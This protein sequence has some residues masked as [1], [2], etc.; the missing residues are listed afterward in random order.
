MGALVSTK[1][2]SATRDL[3]VKICKRVLCLIRPL[4]SVLSANTKSNPPIGLKTKSSPI[5]P[6]Q[7]K[8]RVTMS[9]MVAHHCKIKVFRFQDDSL[10]FELCNAQGYESGHQCTKA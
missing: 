8:L 3:V 10:Y 1:F 2:E 4:S 6:H 5:G 7:D 9:L